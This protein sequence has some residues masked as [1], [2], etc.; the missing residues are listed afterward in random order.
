MKGRFIVL[1]G[2]SGSGKGTQLIRL[3]ERIYKQNE[4]AEVLLTR[5]PSGGSFGRRTR[6]LREED[7]QAG[8]SPAE[9]VREYIELYT[10]D[11]LDHC[12]RVIGPALAA[13][14]TVVSDRYYH[15]RLTYQVAQG[16]SFAEVLALQRQRGIIIPDMTFII[17]VPPKAALTRIDARK[18]GRSQLERVDYMTDMARRYREL[19]G[20]LPDEDIVLIQGD[21]PE[22]EV[23]DSIWGHCLE[24]SA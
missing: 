11:T 10:Q 12:A 4:Y 7:K 3:A 16:L 5:E 2:I 23:H 18:S 17:D 6:E 14:V 8:R 15:S 19:P 22:S 24:L 1:E 21:R 20:L 9:R 13:G